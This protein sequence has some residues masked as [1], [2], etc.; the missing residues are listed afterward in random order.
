MSAIP[1]RALAALLCAVLSSTA[2]AAERVLFDPRHMADDDWESVE[3]VSATRYELAEHD[4]VL[5]LRATGEHSA[6][7]MM[8]KLDIDV[9]ACGD[10]RW[11]W[12]VDRLQ[13]SADLRDREREDV[14][15]SLYLLFGDPGGKP[16]PREVPT[17][18]YVWAGPNNPVG[19]IITSPFLPKSIRSLVLRSGDADLGRWVRERRN[20]A[21]DYAFVFGE[22]ASAPLRAIMLF[23]DNDQTGEPVEAWYA[24]VRIDCPGVE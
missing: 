1:R 6:S 15:A 17:L 19:E 21:A 9:R 3:L 20:P 7:G 22:P 5:A 24:K 10:L 8:R 23:T 12:R 11:R 2:L 4:G 14:A 13:P 16:F 18:R